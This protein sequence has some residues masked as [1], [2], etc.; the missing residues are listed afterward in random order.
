MSD[1]WSNYYD[2]TAG[3]KP[4]DLFLQGFKA[5]PTSLP[6]VSTEVGFG[7]GNEVMYLLEKRWQVTAIDAEQEAGDRLLKQ[8]G[9]ESNLDIV[10]DTYEN[11]TFPIV[12]FVH[13]GYS[14]PF[15]HPRYF[16]DVW[17]N[18]VENISKNGIFSGQLFG[19]NDE[20][21]NNKEMTFF[22]LKEV[23]ELLEPF[24]ILHLE[25]TDKIRATATGA[26]KHW[27]IFDIIGKKV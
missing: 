14:L 22:E 7:A 27:H 2:V 26:E 23:K 25:E 21:V 17:N 20:W 9:D 5:V 19:V 6:K 3:R 8:V 11:I 4:R 24:E 1:R 18:L 13:A 16:Y 10:I 12:S 15:C